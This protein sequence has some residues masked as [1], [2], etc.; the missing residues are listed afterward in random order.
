MRQGDRTRSP[1]QG[2]S[3]L[4]RATV[5]AEAYS[6]LRQTSEECQEV[7]LCLFG[8]LVNL[9]YNPAC[10]PHPSHS[11]KDIATKLWL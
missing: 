2:F 9:C 10:W 8:S 11:G 4:S 6:K 3:M 1:L 5:I 7:R